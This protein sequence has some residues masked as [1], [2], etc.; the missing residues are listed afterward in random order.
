MNIKTTITALLLCLLLTEVSGNRFI[1]PPRNGEAVN[2]TF[3]T[4]VYEGVYEGEGAFCDYSQGKVF[5]MEGGKIVWEHA[6]PESNDIW[7]LPNG[8]ILFSTGKGVLEMTRGNDTVFYYKSTSNIFACQ[9]LKNGNTFVGESNSGRLLEI[10][11]KGKIVSETCILQEGVTDAGHAFMRN[12]RLLDNGNFLVA[13]YEAEKVTEYDK[14][15][16]VVS[17]FN[18]PGGPHSVARLPDGHTMVSIAD[19]NN[20]SRLV[21]LDEQ[22]NTVWSLTNKDIPG[23]PLKFLG[24]FHYF[25]DGTLAIANWL[26]HLRNGTGIHLL[27]INKETKE[28]LYKIESTEG[29]KTISSIYLIKPGSNISYH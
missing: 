28:I 1:I 20:D 8:N 13:H 10:T 9:R 24:G 14:K 29:I 11:P 2:D 6:A 7:V 25:P 21:E 26:G 16:K 17:S 15:G 4:L 12:A 5:V 22:G 3:K 18:L 27:I 23:E 19:K